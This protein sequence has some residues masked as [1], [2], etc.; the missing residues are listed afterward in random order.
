MKKLVVGFFSLAFSFLFGDS[1]ASVS[2]FVNV[3]SKWGKGATVPVCFENPSSGNLAGRQMVKYVVENSWEKVADINFD[4]KTSA[5]GTTNTGIII[6]ITDTEKLECRG[7]TSRDAGRPVTC[8]IWNDVTGDAISA[9]MILNFTFNNFK[10]AMSPVAPDSSLRRKQINRMIFH[11]AIH[12]FGH[13]IGFLHEDDRVAD[14]KEAGALL[15][16]DDDGE[17][18]PGQAVWYYDIHSVMHYLCNHA[19]NWSN[20]PPV[21]LSCGDMATV[22]WMYGDRNKG[23][24]PKCLAANAKSD[25]LPTNLPAGYSVPAGGYDIGS[26]ADTYE[27]V[28]NPVYSPIA[29]NGWYLDYHTQPDAHSTYP[30]TEEP[31]ITMSINPE[32]KVESGQA[33]QGYRLTFTFLKSET[34]TIK[35]K[36]AWVDELT[37]ST[38]AGPITVYRDIA[39]PKKNKPLWAYSAPGEGSELT[40]PIRWEGR[41]DELDQAFTMSSSRI[42]LTS[43]TWSTWVQKGQPAYRDAQDDYRVLFQPPLPGINVQSANQAGLYL[44]DMNFYAV[45]ARITYWDGAWYESINIKGAL[46]RHPDSVQYFFNKDALLAK[47]VRMRKRSS[48]TRVLHAGVTEVTLADYFIVTS[49]RVPH[50]MPTLS[51]ADANLPV[52]GV[53][54]FDAVIYCNLR[55]EMEGLEKVYSYT[56]PVYAQGTNEFAGHCLWVSNLTADHGK[57]GYRL[58]NEQE[59]M[60]IYSQTGTG[61]HFW[62]PLEDPKKYAWFGGGATVLNGVGQKTPN[63]QGLYDLSGNAAEYVWVEGHGENTFLKG[64]DMNSNVGDIGKSSRL[65][66]VKYDPGV[67]HSFR[68]VR[69][70]RRPMSSSVLMSYMED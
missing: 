63:A 30:P 45:R 34:F 49:N 53:T 64:G 31:K 24:A 25:S 59:W 2:A 38:I 16:Q 55:S 19:G 23:I 21:T 47:T 1:N 60:D 14:K 57:N 29:T 27:T 62:P 68:V 37:L 22:R 66:R 70:G 32:T 39:N 43:P 35:P 42:S 41:H 8:N 56:N 67:S 52:T 33:I 17:N 7:K 11:Y 10:G 5:C 48:P 51:F 9:R 65:Y 36:Q 61:D 20:G 26:G 58:P 4:F 13:A 46:P 69:T 3:K 12:E 18:T 6:K 40:F 44:A 15:C 50:S 54:W 28:V